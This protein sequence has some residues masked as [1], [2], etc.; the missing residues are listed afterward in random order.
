MP[1]DVRSVALSRYQPPGPCTGALD[2]ATRRRLDGLAQR[3][4]KRAQRD[5]AHVSPGRLGLGVGREL[6]RDLGEG[7]SVAQPPQRGLRDPL[8]RH[9][10]RPQVSGSRLA[11][12]RAVTVVVVPG[13]RR[14]GGE[15]LY[16]AVLESLAQY[17]VREPAAQ[18]RVGHRHACER[19]GQ[20][21]LA[22]E[23]VDHGRAARGDFGR[24]GDDAE[25]LGLPADQLA[26]HD[27]LLGARLGVGR[28]AEAELGAHRVHGA[29]VD[30]APSTRSTTGSSDAADGEAV[31]FAASAAA[32]GQDGGA[33]RHGE[34][35]RDR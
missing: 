6:P 12:Q 16:L 2:L 26:A 31:A 7:A 33:E 10:D 3:R 21:L 1:P 28:P 17:A 32:G 27:L 13:R 34:R 18:L 20:R 5:D 8:R 9:L 4:R 35:Q 15:A 23:L 29:A 11:E 14:G 30:G 19:A 25:P 24:V 22:P